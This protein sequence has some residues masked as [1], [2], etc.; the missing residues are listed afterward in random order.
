[1]SVVPFP[2]TQDAGARRQ[3]L[4]VRNSFIVE[5][6]AGSGKTGLLILRY[7]RL[8]AVVDQPEAV[9]AL[10]FTRKAAAEMRDR[11]LAALDRAQQPLAND[12]REFEQ[13]TWMA[14][15]AVSSRD[16]E[17]GWTLRT[18]PHR[19]N[20]RT[21]DSLC[22]EIARASPVL[23]GG[24]GQ[25]TPID[26]AMPLYRKAARAVLLQ[27]GGDDVSLNQAL[28]LVL[29]HRDADLADCETLLA[30]MLATREQWA[31]LIPLGRELVDEAALDANVRPRL[32]EALESAL[33]AALSKIQQ[34]FNPGLLQQLASLAH[35]LAEASGHADAPNPMLG[36]S[37]LPHA[38]G[39]AVDDIEHWRMLA[40]LL[41][42][43]SGG[44]RAGFNVNHIGL[45]LTK[46]QTSD[47]KRAIDELRPDDTLLTLLCSLSE[48]PPRC[49]PDDQWE[50]A[51]ALF[52]LLYHALVELRL[53]FAA[54][55]VCDFAELSLAARAA[56]RA[57]DADRMG[58]RLEHLLVD[59]MQDTSSAQYDLLQL[60]TAGW[61]GVDQTVFLVGDPKQSIYLFRQ[62]KVERFVSS[63]HSCRLGHIP[64]RALQLTSN[65]RSGA[66][67]VRAFNQ[68]FAAV[69]QDGGP[70]GY[71]AARPALNATP[72][73]QLEW[74]SMS[75]ARRSDAVSKREET[76]TEDRAEAD[77]IASIILALQRLVR[78][79]VSG[80]PRTM[81]VLV[82]S[83]KHAL[84]V[85][86][87]LA[88]AQIAFRAVDM[89][90]LA[91]RPEV[92][93]ALAIARALLHPA[94]RT[95]WLATLRAP[96][97]GLTLTDLHLVTG[98]DDRT[99]RKQ[100]LRSLLR[101]RAALLPQDVQLRLRRTLDVLD[102][103]VNHRGR[104]PLA[105]EVDRLWHALQA[106]L[107]VTA[108]EH[109]N[110][111]AF[112][113]LLET[114]ET[115]GETIDLTSLSERLKAL[116]AE[117]DN[118]TDAV[119]VLTIHKAKGLE[120]DAVFV[121]GMHR[122]SQS[123][124]APLLDWAELKQTDAEGHPLILLAPIQRRGDDRGT[125]NRFV[126]GLRTQGE[127]AEL[128]RLFYVAATR[129]RTALH[130]FAAPQQNA[131]GELSIKS[132]SLLR[133]A[134]QA[135]ES[136]FTHVPSNFNLPF[137]AVPRI[138]D[139][140]ALAAA[141]EPEHSDYAAN[142]RGFV[143]LRRL[144]LAWIKEPVL[145]QSAATTAKSPRLH[146][147]PVQ[148][149]GSLSARILGTTVHA[150]LQHL[151]E[152]LAHPNTATP[153]V[154]AWSA[155]IQTLVR[156]G[157]LSASDTERVCSDVALAL[158]NTLADPHGR[159][160]L[161]PHPEAI[162]EGDLYDSASPSAPNAPLDRY[163]FDRS[164]LAGTVPG[165]DGSEA[166]W[167]VDYKTSTRRCAEAAGPAR[168]EFLQAERS[169]Y[170]P[171]LHTYARLAQ[172]STHPG[173]PI[174]LALYYPML[175]HLDYWRYDPA[176]EKIEQNDGQVDA[177]AE[178]VS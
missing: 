143:P 29:L 110:V 126:S 149:A 64:L 119:E 13:E 86:Q 89:E 178:T 22:A 47:L 171:T 127:R 114:L 53:L 103:A 14:A 112:I 54:G 144:P 68:T 165:M 5:A 61:N 122:V 21:I 157:G 158:R 133:A 167:I 153:D 128:Q 34:R 118:D 155:R 90:T 101:T 20:M 72:C 150:F 46:E 113:D 174:M 139:G 82:R 172:R 48:L 107:C 9:L 71:T 84:H 80:A 141:A 109:R 41:V 95:A 44:W 176:A 130:L 102:D 2:L 16:A 36:C 96:W 116:Y 43:P 120:W 83:R 38:P 37:R 73:D 168:D 146:R 35:V 169:R 93:D 145:R 159:W 23:S 85:V 152:L 135:A 45:K 129:A 62:A 78:K 91:E 51:K 77:S 57:G 162:N 106:N 25:A 55:E 147:A 42:R 67:L 39:A 33:C 170:S 76:Q 63:M 100:P 104:A 31:T 60:L 26:D 1:M 166:L 69:F 92:L 74:H 10:T 75:Q 136:H 65:F 15:R 88:D 28:E 98:G 124:R 11:V 99:V 117:A 87:K 131:D 70:I 125:L 151:A 108:R 18:Q 132:N 140:L 50:V 161:G 154:A 52:R 27:M 40:H 8:L 17:R 12:A 56:L 111:R 164:F 81:A 137:P 160:I 3:A 49:Y 24:I 19:L 123:G 142:P 163:R 30:Q 156:M 173:T 4:D 6:P 94:D 121:P 177:N 105:T 138:A 66:G 58:M 79:N 148:P 7:L 32:N 59:E 97:C 115:S 134:G 175:P